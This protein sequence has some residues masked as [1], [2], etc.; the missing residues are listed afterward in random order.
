MGQF[1]SGTGDEALGFSANN[2][3]SI[4]GTAVGAAGNECAFLNSAVNPT[5]GNCTYNVTSISQT[6][7]NPQLTGKPAFKT[8]SR[9]VLFAV[10]YY[11]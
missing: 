2:P 4:S 8:G 9:Q 6:N 10:K 7:T 3:Y 1:G 11:F 5:T